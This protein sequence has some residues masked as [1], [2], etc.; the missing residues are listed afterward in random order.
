[1]LS[2]SLR[3]SAAGPAG[4]LPSPVALLREQRADLLQSANTLCHIPLDLPLRLSQAADLYFQDCLGLFLQQNDLLATSPFA[5][6]AVG[7]YGRE[8][9]CPGSDLDVLILF[10]SEIPDEAANLCQNLLLPLWDLGLELGHGVRSLEECLRLAKT[11][12]QVF[13]S[14]MSARFLAGD[15][16]VIRRFCR[17]FVAMAAEQ[18]DSPFHEQNQ[19]R[20]EHEDILTEN[21]LEP[22]LKNSPGGLRDYHRLLWASAPVTDNS[23]ERIF[24]RLEPPFSTTDENRLRQDVGF[25]LQVRSALHMVAGRKNDTLHLDLQPDVARLAGFPEQDAGLAVESFLSRLHK[26]MER[27]RAMHN[28]AWRTRHG[29][30]RP[31]PELD[32]DFAPFAKHN[33]ILEPDGLGFQDEQ[34]IVSEKLILDLF[35]AV[36]RT[37]LPISWKA[38][39]AVESSCRHLPRDLGNRLETIQELASIFCAPN[40]RQ[41]GRYLLQTGVLAALIPEFGHV[42]DRIQFDA[43]HLW[44]V[45]MHT[46]ETVDGISSWLHQKNGLLSEIITRLP[47][48]LS[49]VLAALFHDIGKQHQNKYQDQDHAAVGAEMAAAIMQRFQVP[50]PALREATALV[51]NHLLLFK[52]ATR[53]DLHDENVVAAC[54]AQVG[55]QQQL[56]RLFLLSVADA[57]ATGPKA[58]NDWTSTLLHELYFKTHRLLAH[59]PLSEPQAMIRIEQTREA[60]RSLSVNPPRGEELEEMLRGMPLR[61]LL[62][63]P[64]ETISSHLKLVFRLD[65]DIAEEKI[66]IPAGRGGLGVVAVD[67]AGLPDKSCHELTFAARNQPGLFPVMCGA[68]TL[69]QLNVLAAE[70]VTWGNGVVLT[71]FKVQDPPDTFH[72]EE[73]TFRLKRA[74]KYAMTGK[75]FL[76]Y[77][78]EEKR[79][80]RFSAKAMSAGLPPSVQIDNRSSD[81]YTQ[82]EIVADDHMG[83]LY[84]IADVF[85][86]L[87]VRVHRAKIAT[88]GDRIA[89]CFDIRD[90]LDQKIEDPA[91]LQEIQNALCFA[92]QTMFDRQSS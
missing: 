21:L 91:H 81:F 34:K 44:P 8:E 45:G 18:N 10:L 74:V 63:M 59:G 41:A 75:L 80:S 53:K 11:D 78:L 58:W 17:Q 7:G 71:I 42:Q 50:E 66:R 54:A 84:Q 13:T 5:V 26:A 76:D 12:Y 29:I 28:A 25:L 87:Q 36:G 40:G 38:R 48:T 19:N 69:H 37:G 85:E 83:C 32:R 46:M 55:D 89:D 61:Y 9:L 67:A 70:I 60:V 31:S 24:T 20:S 77:R 68:L 39:Q 62:N 33:L 79:R 4:S 82:I 86:R 14:L 6:L 27:V 30:N 3:L 1:M 49:L 22:N 56:D 73:L 64:P 43:Y 90:H 35:Q 47:D 72:L 92:L 16:T 2:P 57:R 52:T 15:R 65:Q 23:Q 51:Q 88:Q